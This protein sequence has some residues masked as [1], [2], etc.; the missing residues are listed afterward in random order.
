MWSYQSVTKLEN[1][2]QIRKYHTYCK[3]VSR[4]TSSKAI[5]LF[6]R[7]SRLDIALFLSCCE[8]ATI[9]SRTFLFNSSR[10]AGS[11]W[12]T[13]TFSVAGTVRSGD[14]GGQHIPLNREMRRA[15]TNFPQRVNGN[16]SVWDVSTF[17]PETWFP[18][19]EA[20]HFMG[21]K[22]LEHLPQTFRNLTLLFHVLFPS[23]TCMSVA[24][25]FENVTPH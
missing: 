17:V 14:R 19:E 24:V 8:M 25:N 23:N 10:V 5:Q 9:S 4:V 13:R 6:S 11:F 18:H 7:E 1:S 15:G 16:T 22:F 20:A 2:V 21:Q 3:S 12:N